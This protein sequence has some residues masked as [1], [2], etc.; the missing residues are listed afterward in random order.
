MADR[1][2]GFR[3]EISGTD[4]ESSLE[5]DI[6]QQADLRGCFGWVQR[7]KGTQHVVG[8]VRCSKQRGVQMQNWMSDAS[9]AGK[10]RALVSHYRL[11]LFSFLYFTTQLTILSRVLH[12]QF[13][14]L[15]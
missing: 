12:A 6:Q 15:Q 2:H 8:E 7:Y 11:C 5:N 10:T 3:Y 1:F 9:K 4:L 13:V 14:G